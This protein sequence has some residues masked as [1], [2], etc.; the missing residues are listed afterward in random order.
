MPNQKC[1]ECNSTYDPDNVSIPSPIPDG[2]CS[3]CGTT[4][5]D[6]QIQELGE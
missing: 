3:K 5:T 1:S 4:L 6:G 2:M